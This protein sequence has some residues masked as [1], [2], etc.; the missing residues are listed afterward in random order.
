MAL[1]M[2]V[3]DEE[4]TIKILASYVKRMGHIPVKFRDG[5]SAWNFLQENSDIVGA[6]ITDLV[7]PELDGYSLIDKIRGS[8]KTVELPI[9]VQSDYLGVKGTVVLMEK[10]A[11]VVYPKPLSFEDLEE[12]ILEYIKE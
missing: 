8:E 10:G 6:L 11:S 5:L 2:I 12:H 9:I 4:I 1:I 7:M 3:E